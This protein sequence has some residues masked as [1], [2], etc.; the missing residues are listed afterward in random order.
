MIRKITFLIFALVFSL[1]FV[2]LLLSTDD[3]SKTYS[4]T[5][6]ELIPVKK[7]LLKLNQNKE[8]LQLSK[9][10]K[11][12]EINKVLEEI[13]DTHQKT[14][15]QYQIAMS[16]VPD[17]MFHGRVIDQN[18]Q[19][20]TDALVYYIGTNNYLSPGAGSG[21]VTTDDQGYF[22]IDTEGL[23]LQL[24]S[25]SHP[26]IQYAYQQDGGISR[27]TPQQEQKTYKRFLSHDDNQGIYLN[28]RHFAEKDKAY[29]IRAWRLKEYEGAISG[30]VNGFYDADGK[31]YTLALN[32]QSY[33]TQQREGKTK[34]YLNISCI[35]PHM[36]SNRDYGD[37]SI[38]ISPIDG[39]IQE[40]DSLYANEA[41]ET[42]YQSSL[43]IDMRKGNSDYKHALLNKR[44]YFKSNNDKMYGTLFINFE[45]FAAVE[46]EACALYINYKIN[47]TGSRNLELKR[48]HT[49]KPQMRIPQK[50][51]KKIT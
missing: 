26:E 19:P 37:W 1:V 20:V 50:L 27:I 5:D 22:E 51:E 28:W 16:S 42:G 8:F 17:I 48:D 23:V 34:G 39:G 14:K 12:K 44:Y 49:S 7:M 24:G 2:Y 15:R 21:H 18:S 38:S 32:L 3:Q 6:P 9:E 46:K 41:P 30:T 43:K 35:R 29:I 47:P 11:F 31:D 33:K 45:P 40:V 13:P 36:E 10:N 25:I 4:S